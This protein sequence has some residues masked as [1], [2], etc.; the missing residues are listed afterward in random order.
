MRLKKL[1]F[2]LFYAFNSFSPPLICKVLVYLN[3]PSPNRI[4]IKIGHRTRD[5]YKSVFPSELLSV[6]CL[7]FRCQRG[8]RGP[9]FR[10]VDAATIAKLH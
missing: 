1:Y 9:Y 10:G 3:Y 5:E 8:T 7:K 2:Y 4:K 6:T